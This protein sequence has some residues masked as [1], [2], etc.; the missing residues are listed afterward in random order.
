MIGTFGHIVRN[1]GFFGL[2]NGVCG[3]PI[4]R[5]AMITLHGNFFG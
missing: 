3:A 4:R 2:Y 5:S 1:N